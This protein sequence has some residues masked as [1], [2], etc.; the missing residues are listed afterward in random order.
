MRRQ[1][2]Q[3]HAGGGRCKPCVTTATENRAGTS[4]PMEDPKLQNEPNRQTDTPQAKPTPQPWP[5]P[6]PQRGK[7]LSGA[8][9]P[10]S[11]PIGGDDHGTWKLS[12]SGQ[13]C[14]SGSVGSPFGSGCLPLPLPGAPRGRSSRQCQ[15]QMAAFP[16]G[17]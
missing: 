5:T 2:V 9:R 17:L 6:R 8:R 14:P 12:L 7:S 4:H 11:I 15:F 13:G 3:A 1:A 16:S 10:P